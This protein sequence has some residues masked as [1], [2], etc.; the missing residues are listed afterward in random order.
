[1]KISIRCQCTGFY[2]Q[3]YLFDLDLNFSWSVLAGS[4][5]GVNPTTF[6]VGRVGYSHVPLT[7]I[8]YTIHFNIYIVLYSVLLSIYLSI[9]LTQQGYLLWNH[10]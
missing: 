9:Y 1:M 6:C 8:L 10:H 3:A 4:Y 7:E 2:I 5:V